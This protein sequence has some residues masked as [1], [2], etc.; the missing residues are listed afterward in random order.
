VAP[1]EPLLIIIHWR[2]CQVELRSCSLKDQRR[3]LPP[4][5]HVC[6][7]DLGTIWQ[8][9]L[10]DDPC[11]AWRRCG[12]S[13]YRYCCNLYRFSVLLKGCIPLHR[14]PRQLARHAYT[15]LQGSSRGCRCRGMRPLCY[16]AKRI[17]N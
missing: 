5:I 7:Y 15:T 13:L 9:R 8:I 6:V 3:V 11:S 14:H 2:D 4:S 1:L 16:P 17:I 12:L 10:N